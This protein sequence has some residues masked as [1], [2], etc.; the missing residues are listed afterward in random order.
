MSVDL[1]NQQQ[2]TCD[3]SVGYGH[4]SNI[5]GQSS[6]KGV[7]SMYL[8]SSVGKPQERYFVVELRISHADGKPSVPVLSAPVT[9]PRV[10]ALRPGATQGSIQYAVPPD[11][12]IFLVACLEKL[13]HIS[14]NK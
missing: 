4:M 8:P 10:S 12:S 6:N 1:E 5:P 7:H 9:L 11:S 2:H 3:W 13:W 14:M